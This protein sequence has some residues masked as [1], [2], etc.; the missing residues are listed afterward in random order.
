M[1]EVLIQERRGAVLV[2][3]LNRPE[4]RNALDFEISAQLA[5]AIEML[6]ADPELRVGVLTGAGGCFSAG[7]DLKA[8]G[9]GQ[10][11]VV[12]GRGLAGFVE[13][14]PEKPL[15]AAVEG[16]A[17]A[18]G[19]EIALACDMV[20]AARNAQFGLPEVKRS[21]LAAA[22]GLVRLPR[23]IP[24]NVARELAL[25]GAPMDGGRAAELGIVN[26][27][28]EPGEALSG[29]LSL[30]EEIA[31]NSPLAVVAAK[32]VIGFATEMPESEA[33]RLQVP[34][35]EE[36]AGSDDAKEGALAF[37][38]KRDPVWTGR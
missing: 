3:T 24:L 26:R 8:F 10:L 1:P 35:N 29:A 18:G 25:T 37:V 4:K 22:G 2:L 19:F 6:D 17:L 21:L 13:A 5:T 27:A 9:E 12:E 38:E 11:P 7:M 30:A 16:F 32:R 14:P 34:I 20:V 36:V 33:W 23:R 15:I 31:T 28:T